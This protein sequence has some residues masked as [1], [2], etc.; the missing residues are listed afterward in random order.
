ML[1][2][3][4]FGMVRQDP[5][6]WEE[7]ILDEFEDILPSGIDRRKFLSGTATAMGSMAVTGCIGDGDS[8][9][10]GDGGD[11][12]DDGADGGS[13]GGD[14][15][16]DWT[17]NTEEPIEYLTWNHGHFSDWL[18]EW[19]NSFEERYGVETEWIDR[20][21]SDVPAYVET[22]F[23]ANEPPH[24]IDLQVTSWVTYAKEGALE[25]LGPYM[26]DER[27]E[28]LP[29]PVK[30]FLTVDGN[31]YGWPHFQNLGYIFAR[32][33]WLDEAGL[34]GT[35]T[36]TDELFDAARQIVDE[37]DADYGLTLYRF[38]FLL[39]SLFANEGIRIVEDG[40]VGFQNDRTVEIVDQL[41]QL[42][43]NGVMPEVS[44]TSRLQEQ[45]QEFGSGSTG[46]A[47]FY[48]ATYRNILNQGDWVNSDTLSQNNFPGS[49]LFTHALF[50]PSQYDEATKTGASK[51]MLHTTNRENAVLWQKNVPNPV[52]RMDVLD[53]YR[54]DSEFADWRESN[55]GLAKQLDRITTA[56]EEGT[57]ATPPKV[58]GSFEMYGAIDSE[59]SAAALGEKSAQ[60][61]VDN[62]AQQVEQVLN[63]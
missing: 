4:M 6:D 36:S 33:K 21:A 44:W 45:T 31:L 5:G 60:Q 30:E 35:P 13:D 3:S 38:S 47:L 11:D 19:F 41:Q 2:K 25:P 26:P 32:N 9:D 24:V 18:P 12:S 16:S 57:T 48:G 29:Q 10:G 63:R 34:D 7:D 55:P 46:M 15:S 62:A 51:L 23:Q 58:E 50:M 39:W 1:A 59:F 43:N 28:Q 17:Q 54:N 52:S 49:F 8:G 61:A 56:M 53:A 42:T 27:I 20:A 40:E 14:E 37:T 22:Q